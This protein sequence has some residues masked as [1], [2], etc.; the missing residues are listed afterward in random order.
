M[1][2]IAVITITL[3][4]LAC[5]LPMAQGQNPQTENPGVSPEPAVEI[6]TQNK[7]TTEEQQTLKRLEKQL[8]QLEIENQ[9]LKKEL[10]ALAQDREKAVQAKGPVKVTKQEA[11]DAK[12]KAVKPR[13]KASKD[14]SKAEAEALKAAAHAKQWEHW[15]N[16]DEFKQWQ[17]DMEVWAKEQA[18]IHENA[19]KPNG[20]A[21]SS[22]THPMPAMPPMPVMPHPE[23]GQKHLDMNAHADAH[24]DVDAHVAVV[25]EVTVTIPPMSTGVAVPVLP[26][27]QESVD[28]ISI[29]S[30]K[31]K[32]GKFAA[33]KL[34]QLDLKVEP[35]KPFIVRNSVGNITLRPSKDGTCEAKAVIRAEA[36]TAA[37]AQK[38]VQEIS[39]NVESSKEKFYLKP[40]KPDDNQW[41]ELNVDL[42]I[43][44]PSDVQPDIKTDMGSIELLN[45][46][47]QIKAVT[48]MGSIKAVNTTGN[49][50]LTTRM[51]SIDFA[52]PKDLSARLLADTKMGSIKSELPLDID[53]SDMFKKKAEGTI[54]T[55]QANIR[56][57]TDMGSVRLRW[58][59]ASEPKAASD[60]F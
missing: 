24:V 58:Q 46:E 4:L 33:T 41:S 43:T 44:I 37:E 59:S 36:D 42:I 29:K 11:A 54:G 53:Q 8:Q 3:I 2:N 38:K 51:G 6:S 57:H 34:M 7:E 19:Q 1:K 13:I 5:V 60:K 35:G 12:D 25:P 39:M 49:L 30:G 9:K 27:G 40:V 32:D 18:K 16:S 31:T 50:E 28:G 45:L 21:F 26:D 56:L 47:R 22:A 20:D 55:G 52:A 10:Q 23:A 48:D 15:A 17:K 14:A